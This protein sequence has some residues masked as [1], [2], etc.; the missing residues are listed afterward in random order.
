MITMSK[1]ELEREAAELDEEIHRMEQKRMMIDK[2]LMGEE[3]VEAEEL[4]TE[5]LQLV[6][7]LQENP[8]PSILTVSLRE[9]MDYYR[10]RI[11]RLQ[12]EGGEHP[13]KSE[14]LNKEYG[15][16]F[17]PGRSSTIRIDYTQHRAHDGTITN[18]IDGKWISE[19]HGYLKNKLQEYEGHPPDIPVTLLVVEIEDDRIAELS[20]STIN[21][22]D[23]TFE[24]D[25]PEPQLKMWDRIHNPESDDDLELAEHWRVILGQGF[26]MRNLNLKLFINTAQKFGEGKKVWKPIIHWKGWPS[27][28]PP[29]SH[30][31]IAGI[32]RRNYLPPKP[33]AR[34]KFYRIMRGNKLVLD[35]VR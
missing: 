22:F 24:S 35:G 16:S 30:Y 19:M 6:R 15:V 28:D 13:S 11:V 7:E 20:N 1:K 3:T 5:R 10:E 32:I 31:E 33:F 23:A 27:N 26:R 12:A 25:P 9:V 8:I 17:N 18:P 2:N 4:L 34:L 21:T 29:K 14:D